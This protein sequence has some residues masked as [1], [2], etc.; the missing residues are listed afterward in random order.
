MKENLSETR[1]TVIYL[2]ANSEL[3]LSTQDKVDVL[4]L[5]FAGKLNAKI[6]QILAPPHEVQICVNELTHPLTCIVY[7]CF[8]TQTLPIL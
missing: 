3:V 6:F 2:L 8:R 5:N 7:K 4:P 1:S